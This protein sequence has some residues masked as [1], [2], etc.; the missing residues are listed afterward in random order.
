MTAPDGD[1]PPLQV[2]PQEVMDYAAGLFAQQLASAVT[3]AARWRSAALGAQRAIADLQ[4]RV[5]A[6]EAR[7]PE[8]SSP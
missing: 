7:Q 8:P 5:L 2:D 4:T 6:L 3:E 1:T